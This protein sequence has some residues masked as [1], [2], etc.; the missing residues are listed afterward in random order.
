MLVPSVAFT[1]EDAVMAVATLWFVKTLAGSIALPIGESI[2]HNRLVENLQT[3]APS[4][5]ISVAEQGATL[6]RETVPPEH[7]GIV[8]EAY[9]R[10]ITQ[11]FYVGVAMCGLSLI[12]S[13]SLQW[14]PVRDRRRTNR[15]GNPGV[16]TSSE[17]CEENNTR[18]KSDNAQ[19]RDDLVDDS[20][21]IHR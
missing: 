21:H 8:L 1:G 7:L 5:N 9:S 14:K 2:F 12:G 16:V 17:Q 11:T 20:I 4:V 3:S 15:E 19:V 6:L 10:A 13:S 18:D